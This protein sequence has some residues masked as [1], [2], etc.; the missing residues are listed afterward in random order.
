M[1]L[2]SRVTRVQYPPISAVR[3]M[4]VGR[5][6]DGTPLVDLCQAV[7]DYPPAQPLRD[8]L[9]MAVLEPST[10]RYTPDEGLPAVREA[11]A[12]WYARRYGCGPR[13][14]EMCLTVGASQAFWLAMSVLCEEG[15]EVIV[16]LPAYFDHPMG[17]QSLGIE[18]RY[19][20]FEET[21][22]GV[23]SLDSITR[24]I[25]PRS[26]ALLLVSTSNPTG[27][28]ISPE[29]FKQYF[30]LARQYDIR[31]VI[32]ETYNAFL[33]GN[34]APHQLFSEPDWGRHFVHLGSFGKT[35]AL[36]GYR[37]GVLAAGKEFIYQAL[38]VQDSMAVCQ[39]HITQRALQYASLNLDDWVHRRNEEMQ[40]RHGRFRKA[41]LDADT[42]FQL[43]ASG[44]FFA[45]IKH[46]CPGERGLD[47]VRSL[48]DQ[49]HVA[50]LP[51]E[52]FGPGLEDYLRL[53]I[54]NLSTEEVPAAIARLKQW[55]P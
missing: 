43:V 1:E 49:V 13:V 34:S 54:G 24:R 19:I 16:P 25:T 14:H 15:D 39:P 40:Q 10:A 7:P 17:L 22:G 45:W 33:P 51:G 26:K 50:C 53:A 18:P 8:Y 48:V 41:F 11:V 2:S 28:V 37:A 29:T 31:L 20:P 32:D 27:V 9:A 52:S 30:E 12:G 35:F 38:K 44:G 6:E 4:L 5:V 55:N 3:D 47:V 42:P 21:D 36:T 23:A 46:P